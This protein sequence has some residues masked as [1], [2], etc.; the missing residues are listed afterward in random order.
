[1]ISGYQKGLEKFTGIK[2]NKRYG[3]YYISQFL[4][5]RRLD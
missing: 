1:M 3:K 4:I 5:H 2:I